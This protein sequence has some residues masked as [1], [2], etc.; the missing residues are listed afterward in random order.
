MEILEFVGD[1][2]DLLPLFRMADDSESEILSYYRLGD[3]LAAWDR[4]E[5]L[6][7]ALVEKDGDAVQIISIAVR[8]AR[9]GEGIGSRLIEEAA[10]YG[11]RKGASRMTVCTGAWETGTREFYQKRAFR[12]FHIEPG[13]FTPDKGYAETGDQAQ[14]E[15]EL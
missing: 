11:R 1:R 5:I 4:G 8:P 10:D 12:L 2:A 13:F 15:R 3:V 14:F 9:R 6:G 7:M